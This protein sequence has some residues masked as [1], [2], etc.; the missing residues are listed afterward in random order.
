MDE[1][2]Q[3]G[4][5]KNVTATTGSNKREEKQWAR[6]PVIMTACIMRAFLIYIMEQQQKKKVID[7]TRTKESYKKNYFVGRIIIFCFVL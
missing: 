3:M 1:A 7:E 5:W 6:V 2:Q 4:S